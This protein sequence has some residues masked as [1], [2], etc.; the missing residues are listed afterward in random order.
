MN[1]IFIQED[2]RGGS[3]VDAPAAMDV[4]V[5]KT[6]QNLVSFEDFLENQQAAQ[7]AQQEESEVS[8][9]DEG[10]DNESEPSAASTSKTA[11]STTQ[12][13]AMAKMS[14]TTAWR[15]YKRYQGDPEKRIPIKEPHTKKPGPRTVLNEEHTQFII[16]FDQPFY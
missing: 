16:S 10:S 11:A 12:A 3:M 1:T 14:R 4:D 2:G 8:E 9:E 6:V 13:A 15:Y 5:P 7:Q